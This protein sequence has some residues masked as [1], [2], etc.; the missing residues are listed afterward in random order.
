MKDRLILG[1]KDRVLKD[2]L[3]GIK[4]LTITQALEVCRASETTFRQLQ[5]SCP[6]ETSDGG[7]HIIKHQFHSSNSSS[8][9]STGMD[10]SKSAGR[11]QAA[12]N[13]KKHDRPPSTGYFCY[14]KQRASSNMI[15]NRKCNKCGYVHNFA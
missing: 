13:N 8:R 10:R 1:I 12:V 9:R 2:K 7:I 14:D 15:S 3:L 6:I 5:D 11:G 4:D